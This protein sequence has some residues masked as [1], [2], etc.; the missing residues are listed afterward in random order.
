M[1]R[2]AGAV[3]VGVSFGWK[4]TVE[5]GSEPESDGLDVKVQAAV[6]RLVVVATP[7]GRVRFV[8]IV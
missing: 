6:R 3:P 8:R 5:R 7:G 2:P 4:R 1:R